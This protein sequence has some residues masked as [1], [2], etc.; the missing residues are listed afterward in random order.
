MP[1]NIYAHTA[2]G[3]DYPEYVSVN[4]TDD[5]DKF[6]V[7]VRSPPKVE[8]GS[9]VCGYARDK[10]QPGRCTPGDEHCNNYCN[11]APDK[12]PM[13]DHPASCE[14][15]REGSTAMATLTMVQMDEMSGAI[16]RAITGTAV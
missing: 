2:P 13:A 10:G 14:H 1:K 4:A 3:A 5:P 16:Q 15:T 8:Q 11:M 12:G 9:Y 7:S 6:T